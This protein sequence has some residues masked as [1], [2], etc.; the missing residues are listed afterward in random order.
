MYPEFGRINASKVNLKAVW[1]K[2]DF[3][4][5]LDWTTDSS[6][7]DDEQGNGKDEMEVSELD[8]PYQSWSLD[9]YVPSPVSFP[10]PSDSDTDASINSDEENDDTGDEFW[11]ELIE[12]ATTANSPSHIIEDLNDLTRVLLLLQNNFNNA[13]QYTDREMPP[14]GY[15]EQE[16]EEELPDVYDDAQGQQYEPESNLDVSANPND[17]PYLRPP[18]PHPELDPALASGS[19]PPARPY[20]SHQSWILPN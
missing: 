9:S 20:Q 1:K 15:D 14:I 16:R 17:W 13:F 12:N 10:T 8:L 2:I 11:D 4:E 6:T 18:T 3:T 5:D 7:T 19:E